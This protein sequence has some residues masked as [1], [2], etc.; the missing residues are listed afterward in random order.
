MAPPGGSNLTMVTSRA[1]S[2]RFGAVVTAM[3]TPFD[4]DGAL[5]IDG[6]AALARW[7]SDHGTDALVLAGSTGEGAMLDDTELFELWSAVTEAVTIPVIAATGTADTRH[8]IERTKLA[9]RAGAEAALVV[10]PYYVRP[11]Q[12]GLA[13][14]FEAVCRSTSLPVLI[15]DIPIRSGRRVAT[16]TMLGLAHSLGNLVGVKDA[17]AD[18]V[19]TARLVSAAPS[20]FEVYCG[21]DLLMLPMLAVGAVGIVSVAAHW[22]GPQMSEIVKRFA[23]GDTEGARETNARHLE[24]MAFQSSDE[25]PNPMPAKAVCRALGL[26]AGQ[27]RLPIGPAPVEL[28]EKAAQMLATVS[29]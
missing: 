20:S 29:A 9:E 27:C 25:F 28:D 22:I 18:P 21:D 13:G 23:K 19:G 10:T 1:G 8:T 26:P 2:G 6:A 11:S 17:A 15:Y 12:A 5:D 3:V 16:D 14:H 24:Q 7:L 4:S